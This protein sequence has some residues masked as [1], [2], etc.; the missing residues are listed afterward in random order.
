MGRA[1]RRTSYSPYIDSETG[2]DRFAPEYAEVYGIPFSF[3]PTSGPTSEPKPGPMPTRVRAL[4]DR[5]ASLIRFPRLMGYRFELPDARLTA[6]FTADSRLALSS[7][8]VPTE[9]EMSA[10]TG[11]STYH[12]LDSLRSERPNAVAF[13]LASCA[14]ERYLRDTEDKLQPWLFPQ[15]LQITKDWM[16]QCL[17]LKDDAFPQLL[18]F[19]RH[20][21]AAIEHIYR[22]LLPATETGTP[23]ILPILQAYDTLGSTRHVD[24]FTTR[25]TFATIPTKCHISHV[26]ADTDAWEQN[27]AYR[28]ERMDEVSHYVKND[29]LGF[30]IP[31]TFEGAEKQ[32]IPDFIA[33]LDDG[34]GTSDP[35]NLIIEISGERGDKKLAKVSAA[36]NLWV[37]AV[38]NHGTFGRWSYIEITDPT[39][40]Q[41][42]VRSHLASLS[43]PTTEATA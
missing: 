40:L 29:H 35:L 17:E 7:A 37:P 6:T 22:S 28:L 42:E 19:G 1:L 34:R 26:V 31:Y 38:N 23:R 16:A 8:N 3:I 32:Y 10:F 27:A 18:L 15:V 4:E 11:A 41:T 14:L 13:E 12:T 39:N 36:K 30:T 5:A 20:K 2:E 33:V 24:F 43:I 21:Q 9:T 25:P